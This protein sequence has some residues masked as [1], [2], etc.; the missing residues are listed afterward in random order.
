MSE[1]KKNSKVRL[2]VLFISMISLSG[3]GCAAGGGDPIEYDEDEV[4]A[5]VTQYLEKTYPGENFEYIVMSYTGGTDYVRVAFYAIDDSDKL[6]FAVQ[7]R[8]NG[9]LSDDYELLKKERDER[10]KDERLKGVE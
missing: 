10:R 7:W 3:C 6:K 8:E 5:E 2:I 9:D 4:F 1:R